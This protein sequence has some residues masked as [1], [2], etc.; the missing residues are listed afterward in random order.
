MSRFATLMPVN[1]LKVQDA[2]WYTQMGGPVVG[3]V[4]CVDVHTKEEKCFIGTGEGFDERTD[5]LNIAAMGAKF[6]GSPF[7]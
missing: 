7:N 4:K 3:I 2:I 1:G 5:A 6:R